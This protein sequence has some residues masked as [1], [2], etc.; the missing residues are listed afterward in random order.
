ME[1][2]FRKIQ[3]QRVR[4]KPVLLKVVFA[5]EDGEITTVNGTKG[6]KWPIKREVF[7]KTYVLVD[8]KN[9]L[10]AKKPI[11]VYAKQ[12]DVSFTVNVSWSKDPLYG[13][14]GDYLV[15][16]ERATMVS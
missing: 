5:E 1:S 9:N 3:K 15:Q 12:I 7:D 13:K 6:E 4:K 11:V 16:Y 14:L 2:T 8:P 10:Y